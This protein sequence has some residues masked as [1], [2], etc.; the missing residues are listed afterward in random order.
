[1]IDMPSYNRPKM[2]KEIVKKVSSG[3]KEFFNEKPSRE[4]LQCGQGFAL[5]HQQKR[6]TL[7]PPKDDLIRSVTS[8]SSTAGTAW[9]GFLAG[10]LASLGLGK[11]ASLFAI[12]SECPSA[13]S[14][15][16]LWIA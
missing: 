3:V 1:L 4:F 9:T 13:T 10:T 12:L 5:N 11:P 14:F 8:V 16:F 15:L 7:L 2:A 6:R